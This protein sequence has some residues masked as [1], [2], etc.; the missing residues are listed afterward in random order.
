[1]MV[2]GLLRMELYL[3]AANSLKEKRQIV[4]SIMGKVENKYNV[5]ISEVDHHDLWQRVTIGIA[6]VSETGEQ[7]KKVLDHIDRF[8]ESL[9]K[10]IVSERELSI[11]APEK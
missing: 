10:A 11:F 2:V 3:P 7:T 8:V 1:M 9:D 6:H 5:S 4:K